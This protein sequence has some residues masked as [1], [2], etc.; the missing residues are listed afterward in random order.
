MS[1]MKVPFGVDR[2]LG[3]RHEGR[4]LGGGAAPRGCRPGPVVTNVLL[5][6]L[7]AMRRDHSVCNCGDCTLEQLS[8]QDGIG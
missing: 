2:G 5:P 8:S 4:C 7:A 1:L 6:H 3:D